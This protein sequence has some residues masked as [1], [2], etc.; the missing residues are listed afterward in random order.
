MKITRPL[1]KLRIVGQSVD[2][3]CDMT[4]HDAD[5]PNVIIRKALFLRALESNHGGDVIVPNHGCVQVQS[6]ARPD[7]GLGF[8]GSI[9]FG[10]GSVKI[11][12]SNGR[13]LVVVVS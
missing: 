13:M 3:N 12:Q 10:I 11:V 6:V 2:A 4:G 7:N 1:Q 9:E 8:Q 5:R